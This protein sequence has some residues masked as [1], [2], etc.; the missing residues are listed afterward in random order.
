MGSQNN[1]L[2]QVDLKNN[3]GVI[4]ISSPEK[5]NA[6][7]KE[8]LEGIIFA[9]D[10]FEDKKV[11]AVILRAAS[12]VKVWSAGHDV[13]ELPLGKDPLDYDDPLEKTLRKIQSFSAPIIC[14][15]QGSVW[16]GACDLVLTADI[17]I[18]DPTCSF[19]ITPVKL[20]LP[21]NTSGIL[22]FINRLGLNVA[23][24]MFFTADPVLA[25]RAK[26]VGILNHLVSSEEIE[27]FTMDLAQK[28]SSRSSLAIAVIKEQIR[29]LSNCMLDTATTES[30]QELRKRVYESKDYAEGLR[31]FKEKRQPVFKGE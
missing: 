29:L 16:G 9:L 21:Y 3:I 25:E 20:G 12:G 8:L 10:D 23:K 6:L 2:I 1:E 30:I 19:A 27:K 18:G 7:S 14:M 11:K 4:T 13:S 28:I 24:E 15:I 17:I 5:R 31:A 22:H 26:E